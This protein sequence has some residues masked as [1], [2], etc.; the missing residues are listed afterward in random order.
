MKPCWKPFF[1]KNR[2]SFSLC[3]V[4]G[5]WLLLLAGFAKPAM[6]QH[7]HL[8]NPSLE[9]AS[10]GKDKIPPGWY[11]A[12]GTPDIQPG[13]FGVNTHPVNGQRFVGMHSGPDIMEGIGQKL[14]DSLYAGLHYNM[15][16]DLAYVETYSFNN[17]Y[18]NLAVFGGNSPGDTAELLWMSGEFTHKAWKQYDVN[19]T[20]HKS[21]K[22]ISLWAYP[23]AIC[24]KSKVGVAL[25]IDNVSTT[26]RQTVETA[27]SSHPSC[28]NAPTGSASIT[29]KGGK[30]PFNYTW[31]PGNYHTAS[32]ENV[33]AG[34]YQVTATAANGLQVTEQVV[35]A[36]STLQT[37]VKVATS[38]C[39][40]DNQS[41]IT[42]TATGG[43]PPYQYVLNGHPASEPVFQNISPGS[44]QLLVQDKQVCADT[45]QLDVQPPPPLSAREDIQPAACAGDLSGQLILHAQGGARPFEY[46]I[47]GGAWQADSVFRN[48]PDA[49]Y[50]Y[51]IKDGNQCALA[52]SAIVPVDL[53]RMPVVDMTVAPPSC[54]EASNGQLT[55]HV[56]GGTPPFQY[57]INE[58]E[59]QADSVFSRLAAGDYHYEVKDQGRCTVSGTVSIVSSAP[60]CLVVMPNAFSPNG[61][62]NNDVF[63]P[64]VYD[65]IH[66]Y[67]IRIYNRWGAV[68]YEGFDPK[69]GWDGVYKEQPQDQQTYI[70]ICTYLDRDNH[71]QQLKG[72]LTLVR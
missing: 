42:I 32:I 21:F 19:F 28:N 72:T 36:E 59:W 14:P 52:G 55:A 18:G 9:G 51:E 31:M 58:G 38:S 17:C 11:K 60:N 66:E 15:S 27:V 13:M 45:F 4:S 2:L 26:I 34:T 64:K 54:D 39:Y 70:Y 29:I 53:S 33:P 40:S 37:K 43:M 20:P 3:L 62:G 69:T 8:Q 44:Y 57:R 65:D 1:M 23:T 61:D 10:P 5:Y 63:R 68:I 30:F 41:Q 67:H 22:Y 50:S 16:F 7:I 49:L 24:T 12:S 35:I 6:A 48:L 56:Q 46:R 71:A 25:L 47:N